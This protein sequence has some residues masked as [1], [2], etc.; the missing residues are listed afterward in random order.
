MRNSRKNSVNPAFLPAIILC[1]LC[2]FSL[3]AQLKDQQVSLD[4]TKRDLPGIL[5]NI[6]AQTGLNFTY[7]ADIFPI[8][9]SFSLAV[10]NQSLERLLDSLLWGM[11]LDYEVVDKNIVIFPRYRSGTTK[12]NIPSQTT[13]EASRIRGKIYDSRS[14]E[15]LAFATI[16]LLNS[17]EGI[18]SNANGEFSMLLRE[19]I[20]DPAFVA[21]MIGYKDQ[22]F[23]ADTVFLNI[24][25]ERD[26]I[27]L[28]EVIIR[29]K[30]PDEI[31]SDMISSIPLNYAGEHSYMNAYFREYVRKNG[32]Y[33]NFTEAVI[34]I[35]KTPVMSP[36][37]DNV[38]LIKGR[39]LNNITTEDSVLLKIQS[40]I[41]SAI[42]LDIVKNPVDFLSPGFAEEYDTKFKNLVSYRGQKVYLI[43]FRPWN[44][45]SHGL[46]R[47]DLYI[48][49]DNS[50][51]IACDFEIPA[52]QLRKNPGSFLIRK[53]RQLRVRPM[54]AKYRVEYRKTEDHYYLSA[55]SAELKFR[56]RK[57]GQFVSTRFSVGIEMAV[58]EIQPGI[59]TRIA[60]RDRLK[61]ATILSDTEFSYDPAF[62][63]G[64]NVIEPEASLREALEKMGILWE[65]LED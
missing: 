21:S 50:A 57:K 22:Y 33:I 20:K 16:V 44:E 31:V 6:S 36:L 54:E 4:S 40:G 58:T 12:K 64:Y 24:P 26:V 5:Q 1:C 47:G 2:S 62:W 9:K 56:L 7:N 34:D 60:R 45:L 25:M 27:S 39:K 17:N 38:R 59:K 19:G 18:I 35:A 10:E 52:E 49:R 37:N 46:Y 11:N 51:L 61:T 13:G 55:V 41:N 3:N 53:S 28:Q 14:G 32:E 23:D 43:G 8:G 30:N 48:N 29:Y 42:L 65:G 15:A 63:G